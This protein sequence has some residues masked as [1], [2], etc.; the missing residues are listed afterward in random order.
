MIPSILYCGDTSLDSA[1]SY[2]A[3]VITAAG[4]SFDYVASDEA[5]VAETLESS[6]PLYI[7]SD[8]PAAQ[9]SHELQE[10]VVEHV[11]EGAGLLMIGGW[12]SYTGL[13]GDWKKTPVGNLLPVEMADADD[14]LNC[15]Q[16]LVVRLADEAA[17][18]HEIV[19][20]LPWNDRPP[21]IGGCNRFVAR[22]GAETLLET[23]QFSAAWRTDELV[24]EPTETRP[25]LVVDDAAKGRVAALATDAAPHWVGPLVDWGDARVNAQAPNSEAIE[26]GNDYARFFAQ[27]LAWT[28][29]LQP[30]TRF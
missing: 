15:D 18:S 13:G 26:V 8:F 27:L 14:R 3:G 16:P 1:A 2:L 19:G 28:G 29:K 17:A 30:P 25:L 9:I 24:L 23:R 21:L 4:W 6:R 5:V 11:R 22:D 7:F 20:G 12:E 10:Q